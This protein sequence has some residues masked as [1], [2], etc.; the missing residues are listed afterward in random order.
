MGRQAARIGKM[1]RLFEAI[2]L[3]WEDYIKTKLNR[4]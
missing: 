1:N 4:N 3:I 2:S